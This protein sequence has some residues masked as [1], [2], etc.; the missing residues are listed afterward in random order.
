[1]D[2]E[3]RSTIREMGSAASGAVS[4]TAACPL[5]ARSAGQR[6]VLTVTCGQPGRPSD[7]RTGR[8]TRCAHRPSKQPVA[9]S[10]PAGR[11][12]R[13]SHLTCAYLYYVKSSQSSSDQRRRNC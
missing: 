11:A 10:N 9:G 12:Q 8:L 1:M 13:S 6:R 4:A 5:R 2:P 7:L 3:V